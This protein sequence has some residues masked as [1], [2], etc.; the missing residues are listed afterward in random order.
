MTYWVAMFSPFSGLFI[1]M[2]VALFLSGCLVFGGGSKAP[3]AA[4]LCPPCQVV[5]ERDQNLVAWAKECGDTW[6]AELE[7]KQGGELSEKM[8]GLLDAAENQCVEKWRR[9]N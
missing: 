7:M 5:S 2:L 6:Q 8:K 1:A 4:T 9:I 3:S